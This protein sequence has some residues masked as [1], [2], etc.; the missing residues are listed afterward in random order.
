MPRWLCSRSV[1]VFMGRCHLLACTGV[2]ICSECNAGLFC[3]QNTLLE[4]NWSSGS[5]AGC[6]WPRGYRGPSASDT[7]ELTLCG[8]ASRCASWFPESGHLCPPGSA[9]PRLGMCVCGRGGDRAGELG[10]SMSQL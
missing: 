9:S 8:P 6:S 1:C 7:R 3:K 4:R 5:K 10:Y 2:M